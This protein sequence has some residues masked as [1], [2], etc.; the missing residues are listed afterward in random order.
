[1]RPLSRRS[2]SASRVVS[3]KGKHQ[4]FRANRATLTRKR[5]INIQK[6]KDKDE[7]KLPPRAA[8]YENLRLN[9]S[10]KPWKRLTIEEQIEI[11]KLIIAGAREKYHNSDDFITQMARDLVRMKEGLRGLNEVFHEQH[12]Q[13]KIPVVSPDT[14]RK[15]RN[16]ISIFEAVLSRLVE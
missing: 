5:A 2:M 12:S 8:K 9:G 3:G 1:M 10:E 15:E 4:F 7:L 11:T 14:L 6:I 16:L 13:G